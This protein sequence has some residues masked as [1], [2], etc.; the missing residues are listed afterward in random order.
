MSQNPNLSCGQDA[1]SRYHIP[2]LENLKSPSN[3]VEQK[4]SLYLGIKSTQ[5][6]IFLLSGYPSN[7]PRNTF[8][9][10]PITD[11]PRYQSV[12]PIS[13]SMVNNLPRIHKFMSLTLAYI[14]FR[15]FLSPTLY[16]TN[17]ATTSPIQEESSV[18][19]LQQK[20]KALCLATIAL[21]GDG[22]INYT[23]FILG[24][25]LC[26]KSHFSKSHFDF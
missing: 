19:S 7:S 2:N 21:Q 14:W 22:P 13:T 3:K 18:K 26:C 10:P 8:G 11:I 17:Q 12:V 15:I 20:T 6:Q 5:H 16:S 4:Q 1:I 9:Y 23:A 24:C 25:I